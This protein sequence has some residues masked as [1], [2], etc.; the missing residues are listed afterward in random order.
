M[1]DALFDDLLAEPALPPLAEPRLGAAGVKWTRYSG[2][3]KPCDFCVQRIHQLTAL[4]APFPNTASHK[5]VGP[6]D[7]LLLC[8]VDAEE[9]RR[10]DAAADLARAAAIAATGERQAARKT[11]GKRRREGAS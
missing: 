2:T 9:Q 7:T 1:P 6:N 3:R 4:Q 10:K 8:N 5:R 11:S